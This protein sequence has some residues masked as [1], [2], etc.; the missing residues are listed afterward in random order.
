MHKFENVFEWNY[1]VDGSVSLSDCLFYADRNEVKLMQDYCAIC[2][3]TYLLPLRE[4][5][6]AQFH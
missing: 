2:L 1:I 5:A 4:A 6:L 3:F